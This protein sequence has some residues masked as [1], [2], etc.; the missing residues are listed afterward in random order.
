M[1]TK[2]I[3]YQQNKELI[4]ESCEFFIGPTKYLEKKFVNKFELTI[5]KF[6]K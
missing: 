3:Y 6:I 2:R 5:N 1:K 4:K